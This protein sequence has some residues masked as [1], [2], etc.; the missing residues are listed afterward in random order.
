[1]R[2]Q[3]GP[4]AAVGL[5]DVTEVRVVVVDVDFS[6]QGCWRETRRHRLAGTTSQLAGA[7]HQAMR[8]V[9]AAVGVVGVVVSV[10]CGRAR[11]SGDDLTVRSV[12]DHMLCGGEGGLEQWA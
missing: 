4:C 3:G 8:F 2:M 7:R 6:G 9:V 5:R 10:L 1:M 12:M 11:I